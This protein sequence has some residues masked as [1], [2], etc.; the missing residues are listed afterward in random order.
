M[1]ARAEQVRDVDNLLQRDDVGREC[2]EAVDEYRT[3]AGPAMMCGAE[4]VLRQDA[5]TGDHTIRLMTAR[6]DA[7]RSAEEMQPSC[8]GR[9]ETS[10]KFASGWTTGRQRV[11]LTRGPGGAGLLVID[12]TG[13]AKKG[14]R[15]AG[16]AASSPAP[17]ARS[18]TARSG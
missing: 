9:V 1:P 5:H 10:P 13:F 15:S 12:E 6:A 18:T 3:A 17:W 7:E 14:T 8:G 4:D 16:V 11:A 2:A